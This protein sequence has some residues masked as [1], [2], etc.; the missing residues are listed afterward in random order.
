MRLSSFVI[1]SSINISDS[2]ELGQSL[3]IAELKRLKEIVLIAQSAES[4]SETCLYLLDEVFHGTNSHERRIATSLILDALSRF[5]AMGI[6]TTHDTDF[7]QTMET[8]PDVANMHLSES[9]DTTNGQNTMTFDL[10]SSSRNFPI[11]ECAAPPQVVEISFVG[12]V[13]GRFAPVCED[14]REPDVMRNVRGPVCDVRL[15]S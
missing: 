7:A 3:F 13:S 15:G 10:P 8:K 11:D 2:L 6:V 14:L 4:H 5:R 9:M 12:R 1:T